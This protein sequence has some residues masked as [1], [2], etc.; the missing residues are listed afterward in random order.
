MEEEKKIEKRIECPGCGKE[1][2][3]AEMKAYKRKNFMKFKMDTNEIIF[4]IMI[5]M[6]VLLA[7]AYKA[8][9]KASRE[10]MSNMTSGDERACVGNCTMECHEFYTPANLTSNSNVP[11]TTNF[12]N[13]P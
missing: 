7:V 9:T 13:V 8:D 4:I 12:A 6:L 1:T 11:T 10:W 2:T 3:K 5:V